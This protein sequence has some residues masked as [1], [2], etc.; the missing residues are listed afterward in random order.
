MSDPTFH[1]ENYKKYK[2]T[3]TRPDG[4]K[5]VERR[6]I[7]ASILMLDPAGH[8]CWVPL[9]CGPSQ[10]EEE[11]NYRQSILK[12]KR[13]AGWYATGECPQTGN[14]AERAKLPDYLTGR[15]ICLFGANG[16]KIDQRN[17]CA[18]IVEMQM[19]RQA[20]N[21]RAMK[22]IEGK[23]QAQAERDREVQREIL[24]QTREQNRLLAAQI[25]P[26]K[27]DK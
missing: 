2:R 25:K 6:P 17:P 1:A 21:D 16:G 27:G 18:C 10:F 7:Q 9:Y 11:N 12:A 23:A 5:A 14:H 24:E 19:H 13:A 20:A 3:I 15:E 22:A 8:I 4:T 26:A